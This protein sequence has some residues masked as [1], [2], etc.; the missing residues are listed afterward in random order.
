MLRWHYLNFK[1]CCHWS[2]FRLTVSCS[3]HWNTPDVLI[4]YTQTIP[5]SIAL[6]CPKKGRL[7]NC[8][9]LFPNTILSRCKIISANCR[10]IACAS[11]AEYDSILTVSTTLQAVAI[12]LIDRVTGSAASLPVFVYSWWIAT[13]LQAD[14]IIYNLRDIITQQSHSSARTVKLGNTPLFRNY[15][16]ISQIREYYI[17]H[18]LKSS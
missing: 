6:L 18:T 1:C 17:K 7:Q 10:S 8:S 12:I 16:K 9:Y 13:K 11:M 3:C 5:W 14:F 2:F 15:H 4:H